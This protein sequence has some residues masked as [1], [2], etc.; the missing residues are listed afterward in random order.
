VLA[1]PVQRRERDMPT[2]RGERRHRLPRRGG[3][4]RR[5]GVVHGV[6]TTCPTNACAHRRPCAA[7]PRR[8]ATQPRTARAPA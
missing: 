4:L 5:R 7:P 1:R 3:K 6:S 2:P 8:D